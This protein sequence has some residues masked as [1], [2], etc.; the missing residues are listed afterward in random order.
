MSHAP[1]LG[2][3]LAAGFGKRLRPLTNGLPKPLVELAGKPLLEH[4]LDA[5]ASWEVEHVFVNS[6]HV[7]E[8]LSAWHHSYTRRDFVT[9]VDEPKL[10]GTGGGIRNALLPHLKTGEHA[11]VSN[12]DILFRP[13]LQSVFEKHRE[14]EAFA[15]MV[16]RAD[17]EQERYG[18]IGADASGRMTRLLNA[19]DTEAPNQGMFSGVHVLSKGAIV[20]LPEE[21][22]AV[23]RGYQQWFSQGRT[24]GA[25]VDDS[26]WYDAGEYALFV[27]LESKLASGELHWPPL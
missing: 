11:V 27:D 21:G 15:S 23:R 7:G 12:G 20:A 6:H 5:M 10:L 19:G 2:M 16:I 22:C 24:L 3:V 25:F 13:A 18:V 1:R 8:K 14:L 9:L 26:P 4:A 17:P